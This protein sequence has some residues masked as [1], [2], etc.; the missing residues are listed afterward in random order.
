MLLSENDHSDN[1]SIEYRENILNL[2]LNFIEQITSIR[3]TLLRVSISALLLSP[4]AIGLSIYLIL[5]PS[6]FA[7]LEIKNEFG[8]V[9]SIL[10]AAVFIISFIWLTSGVRQYRSISPWSKR[11]DEY[12][13]EK[14]NMDRKIAIEYRF[15]FSPTPDQ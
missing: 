7:I 1:S 9:L 11:Y 14:E 8:L 3:K 6:F 5:H 4:L 12:K 2:M 10:L 15:S 13:K